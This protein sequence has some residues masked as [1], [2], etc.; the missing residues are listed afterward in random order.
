MERHSS[1]DLRFLISRVSHLV[2]RRTVLSFRVKN[3]TPNLGA[4]EFM[5]NGQR[6]GMDAE[7][8]RES[9]N[10]RMSVPVRLPLLALVLVLVLLLQRSTLL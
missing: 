7:R 1:D 9:T 5:A 4:V 10:K 2:T 8:C 6:D 3:L